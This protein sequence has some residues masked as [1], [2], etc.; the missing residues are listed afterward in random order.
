MQRSR[1]RF[2][3]CLAAGIG[4]TL[5]GAGWWIGA[6]KQRAARWGRRLASEARRKIEPAPLRPKPSEWPE[7]GITLAWLGHST[8][9]INFYG[10]HILTDPALCNHIG[11]SLGF[12]TIG[13]KRF[14]APALSVQELPPIDVLLLSHAHMD[15]MDLPTLRRLATP[16][17][18]VTAEATSDL[19]TGTGLKQLTEL[20]WNERTS[21]RNSQGELQIEAVEVKHWGQ[22]WPSDLPRGYNGY[23]LRREG[24]AILFGGD[25]ALT[26]AIGQLKSRGPFEVGL[27]PIGAYRPWIW[28]HC[29]PEQ[30]AEMAR[31]AGV[32]Y[33]VP[34]HHQTFRL[35]EE[36]RNEPIERLEVALAKEPERLAL[37]RIGET[38][39][40]RLT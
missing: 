30:A 9:L 38:F 14:V 23:I 26:P 13:P 19:L 40:C 5:G 8:V 15:H 29:N 37:R 4:T 3:T 10:I 2:L 22:R 31:A 33:I 32:K 6:S 17:F 25:T 35:S 24:K 11:I 18:T 1:R 20:G 39:S 16:A 28:S 34:V 27:M 36:P 21:F 7:N 12:G